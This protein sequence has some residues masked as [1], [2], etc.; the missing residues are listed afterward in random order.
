MIDRVAA[1]GLLATNE[2]PRVVMVANCP[3]PY[4]TPVLNALA[5]LVDLRVIYMSRVHPMDAEGPGG[6]AHA[7]QWGEAPLYPFEYHRSLRVGSLR[8]DFRT[9]VS[10]GVSARLERARADVVLFSSWGPLMLEPVAWRLL[11]GRRV[12][13]WAESTDRSGLLRGR[14]SQLA[15]RLLLRRIDAFVAN[16]S[17]AA[18]FLHQMDVGEGRIVVGCL[19]SALRPTPV[20]PRADGSSF[21]RNFLFVGRLIDRKR[22]LELIAAFECLRNEYPDASLT[23]VGDGPLLGAVRRAAAPLGDAVRFTG[24]V[25]GADLARVMAAA[26]A[27]IVPSVR[28]VWGLVVNEALA[29]GLYVIATNHVAS[30][31]DLLDGDSG[32]VVEADDA[33]A[34]AAALVNAARISSDSAARA[35]RAL[36]VRHCTPDAF[37]AAIERAVRIAMAGAR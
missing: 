13:M 32:V 26:D 23:I 4:H 7:D 1:D 21:I 35:R 24:R 3:L 36:R 29:A 34:L 20:V 6:G 30:A 17:Q 16:G 15:R 37:A 2:R 31:M 22:P 28:E 25:E 10:F 33:G 12:V 8:T 9:Q 5:R 19:P 18:S 11:R 27:L 14:F